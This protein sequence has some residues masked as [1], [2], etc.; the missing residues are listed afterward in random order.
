MIELSPLHRPRSTLVFVALASLLCFAGQARA[1]EG[2][3]EG[4]DSR[5]EARL[6]HQRG[7]ELFEGRDYAGAAAE[8][9]RAHVL[10]PNPMNLFNL[11]PC[12][13]HL[14]RVGDAIDVLERFLDLDTPPENLRQQAQASLER[15]RD[16]PGSVEITSEPEGVTVVIDGDTSPERATPVSVAVA[17]GRHTVELVAEGRLDARQEV[18]VSPGETLRLHVDIHAE[19]ARPPADS[20]EEE[21]PLPTVRWTFSFGLAAGA[22]L[23]LV[24]E[25][26]GSTFV[27]GGD[28]AVGLELGAAREVHGMSLRTVRV[29][30]VATTLGHPF[31]AGYLLEA[32]MG[33]RAGFLL[34]RVPL[35]LEVELSAGLGYLSVSEEGLEIAAGSSTAF[36]LFPGFAIAWQAVRW[37]EVIFR[38]ARVELLGLGGDFPGGVGARWGMDISLRFRL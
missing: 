5:E 32:G 31:D 17:P 10:F 4:T 19:R 1:E 36:A 14:G 25:D 9:E 7:H 13:E 8:F 21:P 29:E 27:V 24:M 34:G 12:Y 26:M 33:V 30:L 28:L 20:V 23:P 11:A 3:P 22:S 6:V 35:R 37:L 2:T 18:N 38:P 15:L 16:I